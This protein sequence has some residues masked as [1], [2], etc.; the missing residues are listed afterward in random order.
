MYVVDLF[1]QKTLPTFPSSSQTQL[2]LMNMNLQSVNVSLSGIET[3]VLIPAN[4]VCSHTCT[5]KKRLQIW[6]SLHSCD[7]VSVQQ[8]SDEFT[9]TDADITVSVGT[10][11]LSQKIQLTK[12]LR[13]T[14]LIPSN[15]NDKWLLV[16]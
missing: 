13:Q 15:V 6:N 11:A 16:S 4:Q 5:T 3:P 10:P 12:G 7:S 8:A 14:L 9:F 2:R 1:F